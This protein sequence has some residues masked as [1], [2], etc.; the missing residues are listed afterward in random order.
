M[1]ATNITIEKKE[2]EYF[3][4]YPFKLEKVPLR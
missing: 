3:E 4:K 1:F 2:L